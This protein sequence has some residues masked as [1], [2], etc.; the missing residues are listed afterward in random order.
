[1]ISALEE[2]KFAEEDY[3]HLSFKGKRICNNKRE[4]DSHL[5]KQ[6]SDFFKEFNDKLE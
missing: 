5:C 4:K 2:C 3:C 6:C 1:M